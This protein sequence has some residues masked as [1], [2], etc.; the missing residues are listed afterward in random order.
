MNKKG[1]RSWSQ[2]KDMVIEFQAIQVHSSVRRQIVMVV[3]FEQSRVIVLWLAKP[4]SLHC[5]NPFRL[6]PHRG[7]SCQQLAVTAEVK[8]K[9]KQVKASTGHHYNWVISEIAHSNAICEEGRSPC[10]HIYNYICVCRGSW[11]TLVFFVCREMQ[12]CNWNS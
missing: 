6:L 4:V 11:P 3:I 12:F 2:C 7:R 10:G 9:G 5:L 8:L 1:S